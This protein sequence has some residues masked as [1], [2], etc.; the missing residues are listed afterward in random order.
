MQSLEYSYLSLGPWLKPSGQ[1]EAGR[2]LMYIQQT[3]QGTKNGNW[4]S[5]YQTHT[6]KDQPL[7]Q[8][9]QKTELSNQININPISGLEYSRQP[10]GPVLIS[11]L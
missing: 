3:R 5:L 4:N 9:K 11:L 8:L 2:G 7:E 1:A 6:E 10:E